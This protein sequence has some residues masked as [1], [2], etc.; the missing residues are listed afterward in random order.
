MTQLE[1][2][3]QGFDQ[4]VSVGGDAATRDALGL[5]TDVPLIATGHQPGR[6]HGGIVAKDMAAAAMARRLRGRTL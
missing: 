4:R 5:P 1:V 6:H 2:L 3:H